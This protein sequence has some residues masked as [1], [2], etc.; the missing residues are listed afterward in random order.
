MMLRDHS[1][2][3]DGHGSSP[4]YEGRAGYWYCDRPECPGGAPVEG[5]RIPWCKT[6]FAQCLGE[7]EDGQ[8]RCLINSRGQSAYE[9]KFVSALIVEVDDE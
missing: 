7:F 8:K 2:P 9:C 4:H 3:C 1:Q 5:E 6:H